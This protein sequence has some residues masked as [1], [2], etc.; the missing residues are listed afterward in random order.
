VDPGPDPLL[1]RKSG[2]AINDVNSV[3]KSLHS[4]FVGDVGDVSEIHAV[5]IFRVD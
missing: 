4:L 2:S 3:L 5:S 1:L